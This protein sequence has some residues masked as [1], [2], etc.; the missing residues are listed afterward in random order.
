MELLVYVRNYGLTTGRTFVGIAVG[1]SPRAETIQEQSP[2]SYVEVRLRADAPDPATE[3][4]LLIAK[5]LA[6]QGLPGSWHE[7]QYDGFRGS[8]RLLPEAGFDSTR[9]I[10]KAILPVL[11]RCRVHR[12]TVTTAVASA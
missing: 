4:A 10:C 6:T 8:V 5:A 1:E 2:T 7:L 9:E 12:G 11:H 3:I